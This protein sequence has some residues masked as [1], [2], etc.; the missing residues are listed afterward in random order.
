MAIVFQ[1]SDSEATSPFGPQS[2]G[3]LDDSSRVAR[4]K[5]GDWKMQSRK[6][7]QTLP[8]RKCFLTSAL[9][10]PNSSKMEIFQNEFW[11]P[12]GEAKAGEGHRRTM[13]QDVRHL[14]DSQ[15]TSTY[16][17]VPIPAGS[18]QQEVVAVSS[19]A[20]DTKGDTLASPHSETGSGKQNSEEEEF[21]SLQRVVRELR[22]EIE[23]QKQTYEAQI[24]K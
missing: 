11:S 13:S 19:P 12:S 4:D 1:T 22:Q 24:K 9:Q 3:L 21:Q 2:D 6:R 7:T 20:C 17:N 16:D 23:T 18:S 10:S 8:N 14:S 5:P 15:R